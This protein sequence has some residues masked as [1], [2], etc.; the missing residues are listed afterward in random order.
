VSSRAAASERPQARRGAFA[1]ALALATLVR[2]G[3]CV[4]GAL[5]CVVG[6]RTAGSAPPGRIALA[7][8]SIAFLIAFAQTV[9][10]VVDV[11]ADR[12]DKP[13]RPLASGRLSIASAIKVAIACAGVGLATAAALGPLQALFAAALLMLSW[14]YSWRWQRVVLLGNVVVAT[15][16][17]CSVSYGAVAAD[18]IAPLTAAVQGVVLA[19]ALGFEVLKTG[20]D[21]R[22]DRASGGATVATRFGVRRTALLA[23]ALVTLAAVVSLAPALL[24]ARPLPYLAAMGILGVLPSLVCVARLVRRGHSVADLGPALRWLQLAWRG[25]TIAL[26]LT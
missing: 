19:F 10:D 4:S 24:I 12:L 11:D 18:G 9:N 6:A 3:T 7:A 5:V 22:G 15:L 20:R 26:L 13:H 21:V 23:A 16:A 25:G 17:S 1:T 8:V 14:A 2:A